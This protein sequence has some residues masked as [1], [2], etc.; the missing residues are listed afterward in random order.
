MED[1]NMY[2]PL[3]LLLHMTEKKKP[4][5]RGVGGVQPPFH[6]LVSCMHTFIHH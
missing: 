4:K 1:I 5:E 3:I 6:F 2:V